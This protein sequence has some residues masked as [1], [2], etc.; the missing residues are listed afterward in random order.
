MRIEVDEWSL[1]PG[2]RRLAAIMFTDMVGYTALGQRNES[3]S[4]ALVEEQRKLIRPLLSR[5]NGREVKTMGDAFLVEFPSALE[6][7]RCAYDVQRATREFNI[8]LPE[9]RRVHL[10]IGIHLGDVVES[11]GDIS[12][13]AVN[14]ASRIEPLAEDGG[15]CMSRQVYDNVQNKFELSLTSIGPRPLKN[16]RTPVEIYKMGMPWESAP[17]SEKIGLDKHR[18]AVLPFVNM[19][20]DPADEYFADGMTEELISSISNIGE[21]SVISRTSVMKFKGGGKTATEIGQELKAGTLLEGS[22]RKA[23]SYVRVTAQLVDVNTDRHLWSQSYDRE[24][25]NIFALQSEIAKHVANSLRVKII[26]PEMERIGREHTKSMNAYTLYLKGRYRWNKRGIEDIKKAAGYFEEAIKEDQKFALGYVGLADCCL[27]LRWNWG[28]ELYPDSTKARTMLAKALE[29]DPQLAEAHASMGSLLSA[30]FNPSQAEEEFRM[31]IE[32]KPSYA[33]A[34]MWYYNILVG[35]LRWGEAMKQIEKA[36]ELDPLTPVININHADYYIVNKEYAK[37]L[38]LSKKVAELDPGYALAYAYMSWAYGKMNM[39]DD[40]ER[41][42]GTFVKLNEGS[43]PLVNKFA[44]V[45][46]AVLK[47]DRQTVER[48]LPE[49]EA[50]RE[51]TYASAYFVAFFHFF[52]GETDKGFEWLERSYSTRE[53]NL[54]DIKRD[55]RMDGIRSDPRYL[56]LLK[57]LGLE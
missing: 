9:E 39:F 47:N 8:S 17:A 54:L 43:F 7:V 40:M 49:L 16:V 53:S 13:D 56:N 33:F 23:D 22:V 2:Q 19:S 46:G 31:A 12:G 15:V 42:L 14:V 32:L 11:H 44:E 55:E 28:I 3:L 45:F 30:D 27:V 24:L 36:V 41:E 52:L 10:R 34:H 51:E 21:L 20:P 25:K 29:L 6:A 57:R 4:L 50:H 1:S 48:L 38:E 5:H 18:V 26:S 37:A 35:Q